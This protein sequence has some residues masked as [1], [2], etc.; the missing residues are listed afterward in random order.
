LAS[1]SP[2][3][4]GKVVELG[5]VEKVVL[6][7]GGAVELVLEDVEGDEAVEVVPDSVAPSSPEPQP[8]PPA[9]T[10]AARARTARRAR[11]LEP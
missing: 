1:R 10:A 4:A 11:T 2:A 9:T 6:G 5:A 7:E 3:A 8:D